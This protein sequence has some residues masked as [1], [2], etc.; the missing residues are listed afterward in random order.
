[1]TP[2]ALAVV[3]A[4]A[5]AATGSLAGPA[6][7][8]K[9]RCTKG[10]CAVKKARKLLTG[11]V[12]IRF[13][14]TG[15]VGV[16]SSLDQRLHFCRGGRFIYDS[17]SYLPDVGTYADRTTGT[18]RVLSARFSRSGKKVRARVRGRRR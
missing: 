15:S 10:P 2:R 17:V 13:T 9:K 5:V 16:P 6:P 12:L 11:R 14:D 7:A 8:A 1:M 3:L 18:W 4:G